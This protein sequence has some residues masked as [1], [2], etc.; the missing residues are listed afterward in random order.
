V[1][2]WTLAASASLLWACGSAGWGDA[3]SG[4]AGGP[5]DAA[6][7]VPG[8]AST[9]SDDQPVDA[10]GLDRS[11]DATAAEASPQ[12]DAGIDAGAE[13][14]TGGAV[15]AGDEAPAGQ[16]T[17]ETIIPGIVWKDTSNNVI[18][19]HGEGLIQVG[20]TVYWFGEDKTHGTNFQNINCYSTDDLT[21]F[22]F[23]A[24]VLTL[25]SSG[26]L[27][28]GRIVERPKVL[29]NSSTS[30]YV[31]YMHID[32]TS[33]AERKVGVATS[34][35][36]CG[37]YA[38][39]GSFQPLGNQS[40]DMS[41][42]QDADG[43][44]YL[45]SEDRASKLTRIDQLSS[46]YL[47]VVSS[48][49]GN[50]ADLEAP[51]MMK[52]GSTYYLFGSHQSGW[53]TNDNEYITATNLAG[54]WSSWATF[55]PVGSKTCNSQTA[56]ILPIHGSQTTSYIYLGDRWNSGNLSDSRYVWL[57]LTIDGTGVSMMCDSSWVIDPVTG[58]W[59][60]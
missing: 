58:V 7:A 42:F 21:H 41:L 33:Y 29:F 31:M 20:Q 36:V 6:I 51:A 57:P 19:A 53:S 12:A 16:G 28:P 2:P 45:L 23:E 52:M 40:L 38:Y 10:P 22:K 4:D 8:D 17:Q 59:S 5:S 24:H 48:V 15:D 54:P 32:N 14:A 3:G 34:S 49:Y 18:Q 27:G 55:A 39:R 13:A 25:Q 26:D 56:Y 30:T 9:G 47:T 35:S 50:S 44:G 11:G 43:T 1:T 60:Q 46:D 37:S